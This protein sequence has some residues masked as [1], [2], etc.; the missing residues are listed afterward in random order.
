VVLEEQVSGAFA[1]RIADL[2]KRVEY[3]RADSQEDKEAIYRFRHE[4][5]TRDGSIPPHP[6]GLFHDAEDEVPNAWLIG[7]YIDGELASS[8][9]LHIGSRPEHYIPAAKVF[10]DV[11]LPHLRAGELLIDGSR[12][13]SRLDFVREYPF[14]TYITMRVIFLAEDHFGADYILAAARLEYALAF[15]RMCGSAQWAPPRLYPPM[16]K[17]VALTAYDCKANWTRTR[18]RYPAARSTPEERIALFGRSSTVASDPYEELTA[19]RRA[20]R[21]PATQQSATYVA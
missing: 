1:A 18:E 13:T 19:G 21:L 2:L 5:Y 8:I 15:R 9:R 17:A 4:A 12:Q 7:V 20:R 6:A 10:P 14:L 3:R 16:A 11:V